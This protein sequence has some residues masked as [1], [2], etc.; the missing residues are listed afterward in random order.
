HTFV[1]ELGDGLLDQLANGVF[2]DALF[3]PQARQR[4]DARV[5]KLGI[6]RGGDGLAN[7]S[8][9]VMDMR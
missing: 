3:R 1:D 4:L 9:Q 8:G 6:I 2:H 5:E 7:Y